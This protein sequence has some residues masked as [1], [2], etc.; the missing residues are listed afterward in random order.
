MAGRIY[1]VPNRMARDIAFAVRSEAG[2]IVAAAVQ[3]AIGHQRLPL[4][5]CV[6]QEV[7]GGNIL[8][9]VHQPVIDWQFRKTVFLADLIDE[10][11]HFLTDFH[12]GGQVR[13]RVMGPFA[14]DN[15][16]AALRSLRGAGAFCR[17]RGGGRFRSTDGHGHARCVPGVIRDADHGGP[18]GFHHHDIEA[19][20]LLQGN[21]ARIGGDGGDAGPVGTDHHHT[22]V[23]D[24]ECISL[25]TAYFEYHC[26]S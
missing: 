9:G 1:P 13:V 19:A 2:E 16:I 12:V 7:L 4:I 3:P 6:L 21:H 25:V 15:R 14:V 10:P 18:G 22:P 20:D 17:R 8:H 24:G 26:L 11:H 23:P 5:L